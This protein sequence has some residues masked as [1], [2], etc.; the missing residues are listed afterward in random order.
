MQVIFLRDSAAT[1][2]GVVVGPYCRISYHGATPTL[3]ELPALRKNTLSLI[4]YGCPESMSVPRISAWCLEEVN[5]RR[6]SSSRS[7]CS[8][9]PNVRPLAATGIAPVA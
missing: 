5:L 3:L 8:R 4:A 2:Q 6:Y 9:Q 7:S 1:S